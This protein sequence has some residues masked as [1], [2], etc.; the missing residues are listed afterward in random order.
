MSP[1][2]IPS[3][4]SN[5]L[6]LS[7]STF[8]SRCASDGENSLCSSHFANSAGEP[9][10]LSES[11]Q[12]TTSPVFATIFLCVLFTSRRPTYKTRLP[13]SIGEKPGICSVN[14]CQLLPASIEKPM[15][16]KYAFP[17]VD[18]V[19]KSWCASKQTSTDLQH[20]ICVWLRRKPCSFQGRRRRNRWIRL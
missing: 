11:T 15:A 7:S 1:S 20:T 6:R 14:Q 5:P 16:S 3:E 2:N 10:C 13:Y 17:F 18:G 8:K 9:I 4:L 19:S 12:I